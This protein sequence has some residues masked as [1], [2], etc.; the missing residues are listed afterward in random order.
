MARYKQRCWQCL[1]AK[2]R[3]D[4]ATISQDCLVCLARARHQIADKNVDTKVE[5][6]A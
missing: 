1:Y 2:Y 6:K 4:G 3:T 5:V